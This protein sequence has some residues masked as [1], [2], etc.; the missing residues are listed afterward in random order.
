MGQ[1]ICPKRHPHPSA[2]TDDDPDDTFRHRQLAC[3]WAF[4]ARSAYD[5]TVITL[6]LHLVERARTGWGRRGRLLQTNQW[7]KEY[8][9]EN[10]T[11]SWRTG[12]IKHWQRTP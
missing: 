10:Y 7:V 6:R 8:R 11:P 5:D 12:T 9:E 3:V 1:A 4:L 2:Q